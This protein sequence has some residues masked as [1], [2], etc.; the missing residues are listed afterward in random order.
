MEGKIINE[1]VDNLL[2]EMEKIYKDAVEAHKPL[3]DELNKKVEELMHEFDEKE[4]TKTF[5]KV[6]AKTDFIALTIS[7]PLKDETK[8][9]II[10]E[11]VKGEE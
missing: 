11:L 10:E 8:E 6:K 3:Q 9:R 2:V 4:E 7:M 5:E 1:N